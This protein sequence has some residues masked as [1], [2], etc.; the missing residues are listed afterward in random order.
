MTSIELDRLRDE[1]AMT[2][3]GMFSFDAAEVKL[4]ETGVRP[5]HELA[6]KVCYDAADAM[7]AERARRKSVKK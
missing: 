4:L 6:A 7:M 2:A 1:F 3:M 5:N